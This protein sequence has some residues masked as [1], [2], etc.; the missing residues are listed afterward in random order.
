MAMATHDDSD[1]K[2]IFVG[3]LKR[4][5][6]DEALEAYFSK[7]G[8]VADAFISKDAVTGQSRG[9]A[10]VTF[11]DRQSVDDC[12]NNLPHE[13]EGKVVDA[14][15]AIPRGQSRP[16]PP[17][18]FVGGIPSNLSAEDLQQFFTQFGP[19]EDVH[20]LVNRA[21]GEHRGFG[22]VSFSSMETVHNLCA[23]PYVEVNGMKLEVKRA[24]TRP[25]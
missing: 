4:D 21:T 25:S 13:I 18:V 10:F 11:V 23:L 7:W 6:R 15:R 3:G 1:S 19:V 5:T 9:F 2:K 16:D 12:L 20:I 14:K 17:S 22:F 8:Q 24:H